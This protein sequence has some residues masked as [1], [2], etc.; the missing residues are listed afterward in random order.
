ML[1]PIQT[2]GNRPPLF[3]MH[4]IQGAMLLGSTFASVL[5]PDHPFFIINANGMDGRQPVID[6]F[7]EMVRTYIED[8]EG[9]SPTGPLRIGGMCSGCLLAIEIA[10]RLQQK[11]RQT[12]AVILADPPPVPF[13]FNKELRAVD[14]RQPQVAQQLYDQV[15][16]TLSDHASRHYNDMPFD[17]GDPQQTHA[18]ILAGVASLVAFA[19]YIPTPFSG[20]AEL[21]VSAERAPGF[22]HPQMPW[23]R[24]LP[25]SRV[26]H[27]LPWEHMELFRAGRDAVARLLKFM[28]DE[29]PTLQNVA[30]RP[31]ERSIA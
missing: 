26:V 24:L 10:R 6:N 13:S 11:G 21:I 15:R 27:V 3:F 19:K 14:P 31:A 22:F 23:R 17:P 7:Q 28:L 30:E 16:R 1:V 2:S 20:P 25:G 9:V 18:A 12:G 8:I 29:P 4:G 5:G